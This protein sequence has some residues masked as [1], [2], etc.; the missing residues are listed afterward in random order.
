MTAII[1]NFPYPST[2]TERFVGIV[3]WY[4]RFI[5]HFSLLLVFPSNDLLKGGKKDQ[6]VKWNPDAG[7]SF[8]KLKKALVSTAISQFF[9]HTTT[10]TYFAFVNNNY[11]QYCQKI[12]LVLHFSEFNL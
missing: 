8:S 1:V 7:T 4:R 6:S 10:Y 3:S 9:V 12:S 5:N 11:S 2:T